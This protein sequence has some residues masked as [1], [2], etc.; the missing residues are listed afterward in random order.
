MEA[1][2]LGPNQPERFY[3]G[4]AAIAA[5]RGLAAE[6][7]RQPEDWVGSTTTL[8][9]QAELGLSRLETGEL[10]RDLVRKDPQAWLGPELGRNAQDGGLLVKLLDA[11]ERLPIHAHPDRDFA[12]RHLSCPYGKTEAWLIQ[13]TPEGGPGTVHLGFRRDVDASTLRTWVQSQDAATMLDTMHT[14]P[15]WA[16]DAVFVPAGLPHAIGAGI[17]LVELQEPTDFSVL[18]QW[19]GFALDGPNEG[20]L[21][22]GYDLALQCIDRRGWSA[23]EIEDLRS[24]LQ[25]RPGIETPL[26]GAAAEFFRAERL[27]PSPVLELEADFSILVVVEGHGQLRT[28]G[29]TLALRRGMTVLV[30]YAVGASTL[31]GEIHVI[32]C[33]PPQH[34]PSWHLPA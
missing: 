4:G 21:G 29:A 14:L 25:H 8:F 20:H 12:R 22:I 19:E 10:V 15:V 33:R 18:L 3:R 1:V 7:E 23:E 31:T 5:F 26:P 28:A 6:S 27:R 30:P 24:T 13:G 17:F 16:G 2:V 11:G 9:G 32:R 34:L